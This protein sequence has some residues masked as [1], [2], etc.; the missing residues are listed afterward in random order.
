MEIKTLPLWQKKN[1]SSDVKK[2][3][4]SPTKV[5]M[6]LETA[7]SAVLTLLFALFFFWV[8]GKQRDFDELEDKSS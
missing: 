6:L 1:I 5:W 8:N 4:G 7:V 2:T 3:L